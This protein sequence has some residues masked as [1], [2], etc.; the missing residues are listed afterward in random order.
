ML[1]YIS[2]NAAKGTNASFYGPSERQQ[3]RNHAKGDTFDIIWYGKIPSLK[4]K[5]EKAIDPYSIRGYFY[6]ICI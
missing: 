3:K 4:G 5:N 1:Y 2:P 6:H